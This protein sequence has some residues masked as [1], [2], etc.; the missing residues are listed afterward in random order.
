MQIV[1][2]S[3]KKKSPNSNLISFIDRSK[4]ERVFFVQ[5]IKMPRLWFR[6]PLPS[7]VRHNDNE[8]FMQIFLIKVRI[9]KSS[10]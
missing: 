7:F 3:Q 8:I 6:K 2:N 5:R 10:F 4:H 9:I 1:F